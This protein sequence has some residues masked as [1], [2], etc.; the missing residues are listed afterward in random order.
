MGY[1]LGVDL[2]TTFTAA[3]VE[4]HGRVEMVTLGDRSAAVPSVV[5]VRDD[6]TILT[7]DA[8]DRRA[9]TEPDRVAR[10]VKRRLGDPMPLVLGGSPYAAAHLMGR[11]LRDVVTL[12]SERE[13][14]APDVVTLTH[15]ANWGPYKREL[16]S[17][18][19]RTA[20]L[21]RVRMLSE[22][23]GAAAHYAANERLEEGA[24][25]AVYDLGGGTFDATVL[26]TVGK[27]FEILGTPEGLEG[28]GGV[29]FDEAVFDHVD[30]SLG[31]P[32]ST[33]D[34]SDPHDTS[35]VIRL[36][37]DC[38]RAKEALSADTETTIPVMLPRLQTE[39]RLTRGEVEEMI[40]P[41]ISAT[42]E[43]LNRALLSAGVAPD[44][45][46]TVL[47]VG[48][49]SRIPLVSQMVSA[50]L[51]RP[52]AVDAHPKHAIVLG[53]AAMSGRGHVDDRGLFTGPRSGAAPLTTTMNQPGTGPSVGGPP[54]GPHGALRPP[55]GPVP[56][57]RTAARPMVPPMPPAG[58]GPPPA[59]AAP[60]TPAAG[61]PASAPRGSGSTNGPR[62]VSAGP[63]RTVT[64][65]GR[66]LIAAAAVVLALVVAGLAVVVLVAGPPA[67][68]SET[69]LEPVNTAQANPFLP[70]AGGT[71]TPGVAS[72]DAA[73]GPVGGHTPGLFGGSGSNTCQRDGIAD[74]LA[75]HPDV[76]AAW[77]Q[78]EGIEPSQIGDFL[79]HL[80]PVVL[81]ADTAVTNHGY[82]DG[83]LTSRAA[84]L[85]SGTAV[86]VDGY[87]TPR[88]KCYCG[89]P[90]SEPPRDLSMR[91]I[92]TAWPTFVQSNVVVVRPAP[93]LLDDLTVV[94]VAT[95]DVY[96]IDAP[97]W[98]YGYASA[99]GPGTGS[100]T[101]SPDTTTT[102]TTP[103]STA[104]TT[105]TTTTTTATTDPATTTAP[106]RTTT[107][108]SPAG[109]ATRP[110]RPSGGTPGSSPTPG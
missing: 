110:A 35:A 98:R 82:A 52:T 85:Q 59:L 83:H 54:T 50:E 84:I 103:T 102:T 15:P 10:E 38:A 1:G 30:R 27:G 12:V 9:V 11:Q 25:V 105:T 41:S 63:G 86:L 31:G 77:A 73:A 62:A 2:G 36:R 42:I 24:L 39:V 17:Q 46:S 64:M 60:G 47:L 108:A 43:A 101:S 44:H 107:S 4:R 33:L 99:A 75:G 80:S 71:D 79:A 51:G 87:G 92:G 3:A 16:F 21:G 100:V 7:G 13:G 34:P 106:T 58:L 74:F 72:P 88:V 49:S 18:I 28:L 67:A 32:L 94:D 96:V 66:W 37:Q 97:P 48:G 95:N 22:P 6:G 68:A 55:T 26:R 91:F 40:R 65:S 70:Q 23:E 89:N 104:T 29:D 57:G 8:A 5:L 90:L 69:T 20:G 93:V 61:T 14:G 109:T 45:L 81:R 19:P 78:A 76:G 53:A 56:T